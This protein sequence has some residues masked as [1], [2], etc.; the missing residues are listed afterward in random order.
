MKNMTRKPYIWIFD[1]S[2]D[3]YV[4]YI[5]AVQISTII[6]MNGT[7]DRRKDRMADE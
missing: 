1:A 3:L 4:K 2:G 6:L 5:V 7:N